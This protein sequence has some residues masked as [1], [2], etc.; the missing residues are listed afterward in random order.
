MKKRYTLFPDGTDIQ[1]QQHNHRKYLNP[2]LSLYYY[3]KI[4]VKL[5]NNTNKEFN[6]VYDVCKMTK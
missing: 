6:C 2:S 4:I 3:G 1:I 5:E